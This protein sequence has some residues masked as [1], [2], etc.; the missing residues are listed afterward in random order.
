[1]DLKNKRFEKLNVNLIALADGENPPAHVLNPNYKQQPGNSRKC[2][3]CGKMHDTIV[4]DTR[5]GER[6]KEID[7]CKDCFIWGTKVELTHCLRCK[8]E[9][10]ACVCM[11]E[12]EA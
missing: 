7:K 8:N 4:E 2:I 1:M 9:M 6:I 12:D 3:E 5:T 10:V 11:T